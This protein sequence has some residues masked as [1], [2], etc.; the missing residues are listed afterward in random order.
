MFP[1][2]DGYCTL[3]T[4]R[5]TVL[6][7]DDLLAQMDAAG[8]NQAVIAPED[9]EIVIA[10]RRGNERMIHEANRSGGRLIPACTANPWLGDAA[11]DI[12]R[13]AADAGAKILVLAPALQG[14]L[15][16][17]ELLDPLMDVRMPVYIHTGPHSFGG[18]TQVMLLA[19]RHPDTRFI[20]GHAGTTDHA[21]DMPA[22]L[23]HH[24][25]DNVWFELSFVRPW[26]APAYRD[27][28]GSERLIYASSAPRND[29]Q[30]ELEQF[31][32]V[33]PVAEHSGIYGGN[34]LRLIEGGTP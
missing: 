18:P 34:L 24:R 26:A 6:S 30:F 1:I 5:E 21:W 33:M 12:V 29:V 9:R 32:A 3:G 31:N 25:L 4:E 20:V 14:L 28:V 16:V 22:I 13:E 7:R 15:P 8:I 2:L 17:D 11:V 23:K 10:N 19:E 27:A